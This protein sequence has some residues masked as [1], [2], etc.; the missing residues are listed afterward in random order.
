MTKKQS[1]RLKIIFFIL[2]AGGLL[3]TSVVQAVMTIGYM[4]KN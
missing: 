3:V 4:V 2:A 1:K